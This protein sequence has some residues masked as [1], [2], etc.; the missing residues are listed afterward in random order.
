M[1][2]F[3]NDFLEFKVTASLQFTNTVEN[4]HTIDIIA[5]RGK[6][7][8]LIKEPFEYEDRCL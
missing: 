3:F 7:G 8:N 2:F 1:F 5:I 4:L 6:H